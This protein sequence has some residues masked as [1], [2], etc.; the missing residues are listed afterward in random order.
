MTAIKEK[1]TKISFLDNEIDKYKRQME[2]MNNMWG[3]DINI[4][5]EIEKNKFIFDKENIGKLTPDSSVCD[6]LS[7]LKLDIDLNINQTLLELQNAF[8]SSDKLNF[9]SKLI[10]SSIFQDLKEVSYEMK[11]LSLVQQMCLTKFLPLENKY[12]KN[13]LKNISKYV[14][15]SSSAFS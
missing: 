2:Q 8:D 9:S 6:T 7:T 15:E 10:P 5:S 12:F 14:I 3:I 11:K 1:N 4:P 13:K